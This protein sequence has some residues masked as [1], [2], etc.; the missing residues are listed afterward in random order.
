M[1][2]V[3]IS[4]FEVVNALA[5]QR[6][7]HKAAGLMLYAMQQESINLNNKHASQGMCHAVKPDEPLLTLE[8]RDFEEQ[9]HL[10]KASISRPTPRSHCRKL[11][12]SLRRR[13]PTIACFWQLWVHIR[14]RSRSK[15]PPRGPKKRQEETE[16]ASPP[17]RTRSVA[18]AEGTSGRD[19]RL[20]PPMFS[21]F[22]EHRGS[23]EGYPLRN[24]HRKS[25]LDR[26]QYFTSWNL[27]R[28]CSSS[29]RSCPADQRAHISVRWTES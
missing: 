26:D 17:W 2:A 4:L 28:L 7:D 14:K 13:W 16:E 22:Y 5:N 21:I 20:S 29:W 11:A 27:W 9:Y 1:H 18:G 15:P 25:Y 10:P 19:F 3:Q 6:I 23:G 12:L 24:R 8:F